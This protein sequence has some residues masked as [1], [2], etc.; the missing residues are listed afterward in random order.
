MAEH[1]IQPAEH[2]GE[3]YQVYSVI[4][5]CSNDCNRPRSVYILYN[6]ATTWTLVSTGLPN[7]II[8]DIEFNVPLNKVYVSTF[9]RGIWAT[10]LNSINSVN[11]MPGV[12]STHVELFPSV[13][14]GSFTIRSTDAE[15]ANEKFSLTVIDIEGREVY[16]TSLSGK[17]EY[18]ENLSLQPGMYFA[19]VQGSKIHGVKSFIVQ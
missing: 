10:D 7:V 3:L 6:A 2:P 14:N 4:K 13:N 19:R 5:W 15:N 16:S 8:S 17:S 12:S 1:F 11:E 18:R 9:G